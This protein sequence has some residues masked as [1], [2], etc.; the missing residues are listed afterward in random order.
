MLTLHFLFPHELLNALDILDKGLVT[1]LVLL[2]DSVATISGP[3]GADVDEATGNDGN[4]K[5]NEIEIFF[6]QSASALRARALLERQ[7]GNAR[8]RGKAFSTS[9]YRKPNPSLAQYEVRLGAWNCSCAAFAVSAFG[10]GTQRQA[11]RQGSARKGREEEVPDSEDEDEDDDEDEAQHHRDGD[12]GKDD[13]QIKYGGI[14]TRGGV[15]VPVC[16]HILAA[17]SGKTC[18]ELFGRGVTTKV[19]SKEELAA[20]AAGEGDVE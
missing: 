20:W 14:S 16:K 8:A 15:K 6:I 10:K 7:R 19:V 11:A 5:L 2:S 13:A 18:P 3:G 4:A 1:R 12:A 9:R 17:L